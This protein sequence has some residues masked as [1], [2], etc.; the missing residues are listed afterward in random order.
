MKIDMNT[1]Q[2]IKGCKFSS[3]LNVDI[4][5]KES[6]I[7][8]R[9]E[10][11]EDIIRDKKVIHLGCVDH[12]PL[13]KDKIKLNLWFHKRLTDVSSECLGIDINEKGVDYV[14][15]EL[16]FHNV[17][18][19]DILGT[20]IA[21]IKQKTWDYMI[22]GEILEHVD[23]P[24]LFL[25]KILTNYKNNI[26]KVII[27]VPNAFRIENFKNA[28]RNIELI[29]TDHR[30][31]FTPYTLWKVIHSAGGELESLELCQ[32]YKPVSKNRFQNFI[33]VQK[34]KKY[35]AFRDT[36]VAVCKACR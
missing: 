7:K 24:A 33:L 9:M 11:I 1:Y 21:E 17:I 5:H 18:Y 27:S 28:Y 12:V 26:N 10:Y 14:I 23:N 20:D 4:A 19:G 22:I 29:N 34:L 25:G 30:Y 2:Y 31:W 8:Y 35:P 36:I 16:R 6:S 32:S 15:N 13:I 3:G